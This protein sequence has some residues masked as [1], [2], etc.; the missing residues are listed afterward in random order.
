MRGNL[1]HDLDAQVQ[2][3][4]SPAGHPN[5]LLKELTLDVHVCRRRDTC[6]TGRVRTRPTP[7]S[8]RQV[9]TTSRPLSP[10]HRDNT[11]KLL[12]TPDPAPRAA[13]ETTRTA[14]GK[15]AGGCDFPTRTCPRGN[16]PSLTPKAAGNAPGASSG[17]APIAWK[18][19]KR[20]KVLQNRCSL[21][22]GTSEHEW[23]P[24]DAG[25]VCVE[26]PGKGCCKTPH[27]RTPLTHTHT[28]ARAHSRPRVGVTG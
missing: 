21:Q 22:C 23:V 16:V 11:I 5:E 13:S 8:S 25:V 26:V 10:H 20:T 14:A 28:R 7:M 1:P 18:T 15:V 6:L 3:C 2:A 12:L 27:P 24:T 9:L 4:P 17:G 19:V